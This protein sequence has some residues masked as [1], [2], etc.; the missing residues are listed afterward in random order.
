MLA[1]CCRFMWDAD[2]CGRR[3]GVYISDL[4]LNSRVESTSI[5]CWET[6]ECRAMHILCGPAGRSKLVMAGTAPGVLLRVTQLWRRGVFL[7]FLLAVG[8]RA[9]NIAGA[10]DI[11]GI[12][13]IGD[14]SITLCWRSCSTAF[15]L[16][17][18]LYASEGLRM[19]VMFDWSCLI[20]L[21]PCG[22]WLAMTV[23]SANS[24]VNARRCC[25]GVK[26]GNW[27]CCG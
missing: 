21:R 25:N 17:S 20:I 11:R 26:L 6:R 16:C 23:S 22:K 1:Q 2:D 19:L 3:R 8:S 5:A 14:L 4:V 15:T 7:R 18:S 9:F 10:L 12:V 27:Q 24:L 13:I